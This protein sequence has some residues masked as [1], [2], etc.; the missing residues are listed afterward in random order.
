LGLKG[1]QKN[2]WSGGTEGTLLTAQHILIINSAMSLAPPPPHN[3]PH[4][5]ITPRI[6]ENK[7]GTLN[8]LGIQPIRDFIPN[9]Q[10]NKNFKTFLKKRPG[11][12]VPVRFFFFWGVII[13]MM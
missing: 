8:L 10:G 2:S 12:V 5:L 9:V 11:P 6:N 13:V 7:S 1:P 4:S 3:P